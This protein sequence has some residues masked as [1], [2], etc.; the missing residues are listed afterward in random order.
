MTRDIDHLRMLRTGNIQLIITIILFPILAMGQAKS[1]KPALPDSAKTIASAETTPDSTTRPLIRPSTSVDMDTTLTYQART[2][3]IRAPERITY[4]IGDA[5]VKYK[6][7]TLKAEKI[8]VDWNTN[9]LVA[10]GVPDTVWT[11]S[12]NGSD[13]TAT[14]S[15]RGTPSV[16]EKGETMNGFRMFYNFKSAKA[17]VI[18]G[19]TE[20]DTGYYFGEAMKKVGKDIINI[21]SGYFTS[22]DNKENPHF[23]FGSRRIKVIP[24]DKVIAKPVVLYL[25]KIPVAII[26]FA[27]FP[28][29]SGRQS[30]LVIPSYGQSRSEGRFIRGLGYYWAPNDYFDARALVDYYDRS[31]WMLRGDT[32]YAKRYALK[33]RISGSFTRKLFT[34]G[35]NERRWDIVINHNQTID[36]TMRLTVNGKF[37][38]DDSY[39]KDFSANL[40]QR[41]NREI[42]SNATFSKNWREHRLNLRVNASQVRDIDDKRS[43]R[44]LPQMSFSMSQRKLFGGRAGRRRSEHWYHSIYY[45]YSSNLLNREVLYD[46][47]DADSPQSRQNNY[48]RYW[49]HRAGLS[50]NAPSKLFG[51]LTLGQSL[52]YRE[53]WYDRYREN[54]FNPETNSVETDT[55]NGFRSR[56]TFDYSLNSS[57]K[58]YGYFEPNIGRVKAIRHVISPRMSFSYTPDFSDPKWGYVDVFYDTTGRE[59]KASRLIERMSGAESKRMNFSVENLFQM[60]TI[61]GEKEKKFDLFAVNTSTSYDFKRDE[62]K[63]SSLRSSFRSSMVRNLSMNMSMTHDIYRYDSES[64]RRINKIMMLENKPLWKRQ[65]FRLTNYRLS[66]SI[67]LQ[68]RSKQADQKRTQQESAFKE[69]EEVVVTDQGEVVSRDEYYDQLY[70]SGGDRFD[71][72]SRFSGLNIPWRANLSVEYSLNRTVPTN[73]YKT[74]YVTL[75]GAEVQLT[76]NWRINYSARYD[77]K[78]KTLVN[79]SFTFYRKLHCWEARLDWRPSGIGAP[80]F[81]FRINVRSPQLRD[82]KWEKRGG[83]SSI[84]RY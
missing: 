65:F 32:Q 56:R 48:T 39:Y 54:T 47:T 45:N 49:D 83:R 40:T 16:T 71:P 81:Y 20:Y 63:W 26:P 78:E 50:F 77:I 12:E 8:T 46:D 82:L 5:V 43:T 38:S 72:E 33:G 21:S 37:L 80:Y 74:F 7:M 44:T 61:D 67:R 73:E 41:L 70:R 68:G 14:V 79:H 31:G 11:K 34:T 35:Q 53:R 29:K 6:T 69:G 57:T 62:F 23:H 4:L 13:S 42:R 55:V 36:P 84:I 30:G 15:W 17:R 76:K 2:I 1:D 10:E 25:G 51:V 75:S 28:N 27:L 9:E 52:S 18:R 64:G 24:K 19:R 58:I 60:K 22:C 59:I 3:D 66:A